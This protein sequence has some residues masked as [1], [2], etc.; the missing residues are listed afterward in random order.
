[1]RET[2]WN[3]DQV[4]DHIL[5]VSHGNGRRCIPRSTFILVKIPSGQKAKRWFKKHQFDVFSCLVRSDQHCLRTRNLVCR[6]LMK[7]AEAAPFCLCFFSSLTPRPGKN[8]YSLSQSK[9]YVCFIMLV[10]YVLKRLK[11]HD[12]PLDVPSIPSPCVILGGPGVLGITFP[13]AFCIC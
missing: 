2:N 8:I 4:G 9:V 1:M 12:S 5:L 10:I 3:Y 6:K 11:R 7:I 13:D